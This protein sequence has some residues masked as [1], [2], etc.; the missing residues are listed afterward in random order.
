MALGLMDY[1]QN[2]NARFFLHTLNPKAQH[3]SIALHTVLEGCAIR[4]S[5]NKD[6]KEINKDCR[7]AP[8]LNP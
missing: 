2:T 8:A 5:S 1:R 3:Q 4:T 7:V 6:I